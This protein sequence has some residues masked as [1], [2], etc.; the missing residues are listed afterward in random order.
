MNPQ[1]SPGPD[2]FGPT[3]YRSFWPLVKNLILPFFSH[4]HQGTADAERLNRAHIVLLPKKDAPTSPDAFRPTSL[5]NCPIKDV[6]KV[7]TSR[8][9][10]FIPML[11][12][13]N[14]TGFISGR[15]IAENFVFTTDLVSSCHSRKKPTMVFKLDFRKAFDSVAWPALQ[16]ILAVRGFSSTFCRWIQ[17]ILLTGK[18]TIL[19]NGAGGSRTSSSPAKR[20]FS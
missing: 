5:Q 15:N 12:H 17:N 2:G 3:F 8:L 10:P 13:G 7:I 16:K 1:A 4:F 18:T 9:K 20:P 6:A 14:Q 19:L 11:V